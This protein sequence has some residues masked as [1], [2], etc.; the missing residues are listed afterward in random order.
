MD[1]TFDETSV[2]DFDDLPDSL[3]NVKEFHE[4]SGSKTTQSENWAKLVDFQET[5][6]SNFCDQA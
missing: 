2:E 1:L 6:R 3:G 5:L 4:Y